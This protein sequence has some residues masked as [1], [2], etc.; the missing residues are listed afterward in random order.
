MTFVKNMYLLVSGTLPR[1]GFLT[2]YS[3]VYIHVPMHILEDYKMRVIDNY[4]RTDI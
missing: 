3:D 4:Y 1:I 2:F